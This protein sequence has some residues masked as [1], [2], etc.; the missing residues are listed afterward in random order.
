M[1]YRNS[2]I[3]VQQQDR[4]GLAHDVAASDDDGVLAGDGNAAALENLDHARWRAGRERRPP[5]EQAARIYGMK[6]VHVLR[7]LDCIQQT[8]GVD[9]RW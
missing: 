1:T 6:T 4:H 2:C 9:L 3:F 8:L 7:R 5:G